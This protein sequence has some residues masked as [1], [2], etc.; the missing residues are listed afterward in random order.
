MHVYLV[1]TGMSVWYVCLCKGVYSVCSCVCCIGAWV[2]MQCVCLYVCCECVSVCG[3][4]GRGRIRSDLFM[5]HTPGVGLPPRMCAHP[6]PHSSPL[7]S[8]LADKATKVPGAQS[9]ALSPQQP[10]SGFPP[11]EQLLQTHLASVLG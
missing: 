10:G 4:G 5:H 2:C 9:L 3:R 11:S 7:H 8:R 6:P 1:T